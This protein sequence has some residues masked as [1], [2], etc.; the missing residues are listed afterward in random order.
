MRIEEL[1]GEPVTRGDP[2]AFYWNEQE[3]I[4]Y[5]GET[6]LGALL[7]SGVRTIRHTPTQHQPRLMLCGIGACFDCLV[8][9]DDIPQRQAC[10]T[11][12]KPG[13]IVRS[14]L[15]TTQEVTENL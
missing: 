2:F 7:A 15:T 13:M 10:I 12:A 6:V 1:R 8:T 5:P 11:Q 4:A 3:V 9:I 14:D